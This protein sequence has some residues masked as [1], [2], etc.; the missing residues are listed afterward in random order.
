MAFAKENGAP[1][2]T[3]DYVLGKSL[4]G[5][6][7]GQET[8]DLTQMIFDKVRLTEAS[9]VIPFRCDAPRLMRPMV[10]LVQPGAGKTI[11]ISTRTVHEPAPEHLGEVAPLDHRVGELLKVC[12][13]CCR[14]ELLSSMWVEVETAIGDM[15]ALSAAYVPP[16]SHGICTDC[17]DLVRNNV[18][19]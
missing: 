19:V 17:I 13:W 15:S 9:F 7:R 14:V 18:F 2:L 3:P 4:W 12:A 11:E 10:M 8:I 16:I 6:F 5:F 1:E